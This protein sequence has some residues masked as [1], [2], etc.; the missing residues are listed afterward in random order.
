MESTGLTTEEA[1]R[2]LLEAL[3]KVLKEETKRVRNLRGNPIR[4]YFTHPFFFYSTAVLLCSILLFISF[5]YSLSVLHSDDS[6]YYPISLVVTASLLLAD[7]CLRTFCHVLEL[8]QKDFERLKRARGHVDHYR[9]HGDWLYGDRA[10]SPNALSQQR[11]RRDGLWMTLPSN[12]LVEGDLIIASLESSLPYPLKPVSSTP[13]PQSQGLDILAEEE[14]PIGE[15]QSKFV[16]GDTP[17]VLELGKFFQAPVPSRSSLENYSYLTLDLILLLLLIGLLLSFAANI[18]RVCV[19]SSLTWTEAL[20]RPVYVALPL[21]LLVSPQMIRIHLSL[22]NAYLLAI[23]EVLQKH[24]RTEEKEQ[25]FDEPRQQ[26]NELNPSLG[27]KTRYFMN[28]FFDT[29]DA[30]S[31]TSRLLFTL[32]DIS[33]VCAINKEDV[34]AEA[35]PTINHILILNETLTEVPLSRDPSQATGLKFDNPDW[36]TEHLK[37][38]KPLG[39]NILLNPCHINR[40]FAAEEQIK[41]FINQHN[42]SQNYSKCVCALPKEIGF[43]DEIRN[44]FTERMEIHTCVTPKDNKTLS[45]NSLYMMS[46]IVQDHSGG[47]QLLSK[48][49]PELILKNCYAYY[50][51]NGII[52]LNNENRTQVLESS[53]QDAMAS[54]FSVAYSYRPITESDYSWLLENNVGVRVDWIKSENESDP[55]ETGRHVLSIIHERP[56]VQ[57]TLAQSQP[58]REENGRERDEDGNQ[59]EDEDEN[60]NESFSSQSTEVEVQNRE[61]ALWKLPSDQI[62]IGMLGLDFVPRTDL[63]GFIEALKDAGIRFVYFSTEDEH[64]GK[65]FADKLG[66]ETDWNTCISLRNVTSSPYIYHN[67]ETPARLPKGISSV[68]SHLK[69]VD[70]VP[71]LVPLFSDSDP[72]S[73]TEMIKIFLENGQT[74]CCLGSCLNNENVSPFCQASLSIGCQPLEATCFRDENNNTTPEHQRLLSSMYFRQ[75]ESSTALS[76]DVTSAGASLINH[77]MNRSPSNLRMIKEGRVLQDNFIQALLF[78]LT[79]NLVLFLV[80]LISQILFLP[81]ILDGVQI[82]WAVWVILPLIAYSLLSSPAH[83]DV[84]KRMA[85]ESK[86][87]LGIIYRFLYYCV[88]RYSLAIVALLL[89]FMWSLSSLRNTNFGNVFAYTPSMSNAIGAHVQDVELLFCQN[90]VLFAFVYYMIF[91]SIYY[92]SKTQ[93]I[94]N[95]DPRKY[96]VWYLSCFLCLALQVGFFALLVEDVDPFEDLPFY[97]YIVFLVVPVFIV[98]IDERIKINFRRWFERQQL[99]ARI[100]FGTK[101]GQHS[102]VE[103]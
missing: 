92:T 90:L 69:D 40:S 102:P 47:L 64:H 23:Y 6:I 80:I 28:L 95:L 60:E 91:Y 2:R 39:L 61:R 41:S 78:L 63:P 87:K 18:V 48:G 8:R 81:T 94:L 13:R 62:F 53:L 88:I 84:M 10:I 34:L 33:V 96:Y 25:G 51:G 14:E 9:K 85:G 103:P 46:L 27:L 56:L 43:D 20:E 49:S 83:E 16:L 98:V 86:V 54:K 71:L 7:W 65:I 30:L 100:R 26:L 24:G 15:D 21:L 11:V 77:F 12:L 31:F 35:R 67:D 19:I 97:I 3:D 75:H 22:G 73:T 52:P 66:L 59:N 4:Y 89:L 45:K 74:V 58:E 38:M 99:L 36:K 76:C 101:L 50:N 29:N 44:H 57:S 55:L 93:G 32:G 70:N 42:I 72:D 5:G 82:C 17:A 79:S 37:S 1:N 68:R